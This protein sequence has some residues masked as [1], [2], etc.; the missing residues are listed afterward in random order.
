MTGYLRP[1]STRIPIG[2]SRYLERN[3]IIGEELILARI[4]AGGEGEVCSGI[5]AAIDR[6]ALTISGGA[7]VMPREFPLSFFFKGVKRKGS[8]SPYGLQAKVIQPQLYR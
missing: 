6:P 5:Y 8:F 1:A 3:I 7:S 2:P 4:V